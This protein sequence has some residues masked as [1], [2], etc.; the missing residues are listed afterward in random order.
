M[1]EM[2]ICQMCEES[3]HLRCVGAQVAK[4]LNKIKLLS[5]VVRN[6]QNTRR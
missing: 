6:V 5:S 4:I 1:T 2:A 3:F